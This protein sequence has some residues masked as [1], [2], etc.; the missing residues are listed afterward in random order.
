MRAV[1]AAV[2]LAALLPAGLSQ[3]Q[4]ELA[5]PSDME[6]RTLCGLARRG[7][8]QRCCAGANCVGYGVRP[9]HSSVRGG[10]CIHCV[11]RP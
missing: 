7:L 10:G 11:F 2:L 4:Q 8:N 5:A 3:G 1:A 9:T 6:F